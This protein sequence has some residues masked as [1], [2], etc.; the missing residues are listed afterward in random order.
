M[1]ITIPSGFTPRSSRRGGPA[2]L[3]EVRPTTCARQPKENGAGDLPSPWR[4]AALGVRTIA[5]LVNRIQPLGVPVTFDTWSDGI[6]PAISASD[7]WEDFITAADVVLRWC[8]SHYY[9]GSYGL[10]VAQ[11][12]P[13]RVRNTPTSD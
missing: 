13:Y 1:R 7:G 4:D 3:D 12:R 5:I 11:R 2:R 10:G 9:R 8:I 6:G